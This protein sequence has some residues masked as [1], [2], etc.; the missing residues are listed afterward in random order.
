MMIEESVQ[1]LD[2]VMTDID[3]RELA[4][5]SSQFALVSDSKKSNKKS[6]VQSK[7]VANSKGATKINSLNGSNYASIANLLMNKAVIVVENKEQMQ[8]MEPQSPEPVVLT[9]K[10]SQFGD[11]TGVGGVG[12]R[13]IESS[14]HMHEASQD[15]STAGGEFQQSGTHMTRV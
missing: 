1:K 7:T 11:T 5:N 12:F 10:N 15:G 2:T 8:N 14:K 13:S 9:T 3:K 4:N 6:K